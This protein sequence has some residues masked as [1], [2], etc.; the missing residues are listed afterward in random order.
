MQIRLKFWFLRQYWWLLLLVFVLLAGG[1]VVVGPG[2]DLRLL[3]TLLGS[4]LSLVYF[5]QRQRLEELKLF[6]EIFTDCNARYDRLNEELNAIVDEPVD[7][8]LSCCQQQILMDY[9]NL[10]GEE[11]LHYSQGY[12]F[13]EVWRAWHNGMQYFVRNPRV[14]GVWSEEKKTDSYYG[15]PL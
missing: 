1:I 10:C 11:Y 14:A 15:L 13:P 6:R 12:L 3:L 9:F 5:L 8:P 7:E 4:V 2:L